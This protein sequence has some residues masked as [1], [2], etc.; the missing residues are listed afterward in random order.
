MP[1]TAGFQTI[2]S[3]HPAGRAD[4]RGPRAV[5]PEVLSD[6]NLDRVIAVVATGREEYELEGFF[7]TPVDTVDDVRYR[8]EVFRDLEVDAVGDAVRAFGEKMRR[9]RAFLELARKQHYRYEKQRRFLEAAALYCDAVSTLARELSPL[10]LGSRGMR[11]L[12]G[13]LVDYTSSERFRA[14]AADVRATREALET[15]RFTVRTRGAR[16]TVGRHQGELDYGAEVEE[17]FAR[18]RQG[19][20]ESHLVTI[21]DSGSMDHVEAQIAELVA[22]LFP[23]ELTVLSGFCTEHGSFLDSTLVRFDREAQFYLGYLD[24][25]APLRNAGLPFCHPRV[26]ARSK[27]VVVEET[28]DLALALKLV[29]ERRPVVCNDFHLEDAERVFVVTG[30]NNGGKTTF[31]RTFG[32]LHHLARIG[33]PVPGR[34]ARLFLADRI[35]THFEREEDIETLR[36]KL[37]DEL[38]RVHAILEQATAESVIVMNETFGSTTSSD[39]LLLG[40]EVIRRIVERGCLG[41]Y[42]TFIDELASLGEET[43]SMVSQVVPDDPAQRTFEVVRQPADGLAYAWAIAEKYGLSYDQLIERVAG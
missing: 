30:P 13:Y 12:R 33:V 42:V 28:F 26:S 6:L 5:E 31:A 24:L 36:G 39:A 1:M 27:A 37:E 14:L 41:V 7:R 8:Q 16:V 23:D 38:F 34:R 21:R 4:G 32:E 19:A 25:I 43:V 40:A 9:G 3:S 17:T 29:A 10:D 11:S 22:R 18:F 15:V 20:V 35:F 2:L